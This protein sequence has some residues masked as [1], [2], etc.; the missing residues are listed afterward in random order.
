MAL[1]PE[2]QRLLEHLTML[3]LKSEKKNQ[4][5]R[6]K[7]L[8]FLKGYKSNTDPSGVDLV[9]I[10][11]RLPPLE[12]LLCD[13]WELVLRKPT[14]FKIPL[15]SQNNML[16]KDVVFMLICKDMRHYAYIDGERLFRLCKTVEMKDGYWLIGRENFQFKV[17]K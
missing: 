13:D 9:P 1:T 7:V 8:R 14:H 17:L 6:D 10:R 11:N 5:V 3:S 12:L 15:S 4:T 16:V 2:E